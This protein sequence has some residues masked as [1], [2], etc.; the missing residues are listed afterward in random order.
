MFDVETVTK[1][2]CVSASVRH[3]MKY[4]LYTMSNIS[5]A[6]MTV[7]VIQNGLKYII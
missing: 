6:L 2:V 1:I 7:D 4:V 3:S 5:T